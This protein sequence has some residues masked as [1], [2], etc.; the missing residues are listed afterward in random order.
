MAASTPAARADAPTNSRLVSFSS[1][2]GFR[3]S[4]NSTAVAPFLLSHLTNSPVAQVTPFN[5]ETWTRERALRSPTNLRRGVSEQTTVE[6]LRQEIQQLRDEQ[7]QLR[8][9]QQ[10]TEPE[11]TGNGQ[12]DGH[13]G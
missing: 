10:K 1:S 2:A 9:Q 8:E 11:H 4:F 7:R 13:D 6:E 5:C 12:K 3:F